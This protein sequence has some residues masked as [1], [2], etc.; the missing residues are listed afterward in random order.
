M[1][2]SLQHI[3]GIAFIGGGN[4]A[5]SIVGGLINNTF[6]AHKIFISE[7]N[8][9]LATKLA[10]QYQIN[11]AASNSAAC[12]TCDVIVLAVKPQILKTVCEEIAPQLHDN[13]LIISIAAGINSESLTKWLGK[14]AV[15]RT[16]PNTPALISEGAC[17]LFACAEV[18]DSQ[19]DIADHIMMSVGITAWVSNED[20]IDSVTAIS[21]SG[22]AYFFLMIESMIDAGEKMGLDHET[23]STLALQ[24][25]YGAAKL[26]L[27]SDVD[28][29]ELR[30]RVTSPKGTTE[31]AIESFESN[32]FRQTIE[33]A[34]KACAERGKSLAEELGQNDL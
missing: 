1:T 20:L 6:E 13:H 15:V 26:A 21:G 7:P 8:S 32:N 10:S 22:P 2:L 33:H 27:Q 19:R 30:R 14:K 4:M 12:A 28:I 5:T 24:T 18:N 34:M 25:A 9:E 11:I 31:K 23:A 29:K 16:M 3:N 17:G